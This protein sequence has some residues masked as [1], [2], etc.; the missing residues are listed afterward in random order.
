MTRGGLTVFL[1]VPNSVWIWSVVIIAVV[2]WITIWV[3]NKAYSK[4]WD[5]AD[6]EHDSLK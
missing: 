6:E 4:K 3:T 2:G 1:G 5:H